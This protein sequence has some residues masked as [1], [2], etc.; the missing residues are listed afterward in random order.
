MRQ[1]A[2]RPVLSYLESSCLVLG[3][4]SRTLLSTVQDVAWMS[5]ESSGK[6]LLI[7]S[8]WV[9]VTE[10]VELCVNPAW[11]Y[12]TESKFHGWIHCS[13]AITCLV[14]DWC[15]AV[16]SNSRYD[17]IAKTPKWLVLPC[18]HVSS[19]LK[20]TLFHYFNY[21]HFKWKMEFRLNIKCTTESNKTLFQNLLICC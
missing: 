6:A 5:L 17:T 14:K 16:G 19:F 2:L 15:P 18:F 13:C 7:W 11:C 8:P 20:R 10:L 4:C 1:R 21:K 3:L 9:R 12:W